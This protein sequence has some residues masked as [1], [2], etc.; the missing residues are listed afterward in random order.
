MSEHTASAWARCQCSTSYIKWG[1]IVGIAGLN[2]ILSW[3]AIRYDRY[4]WYIVF[5]SVGTL[6]KVLMIGLVCWSYVVWR[7]RSCFRPHVAITEPEGDTRDA[8]P[9]PAPIWTAFV[10]PCYTE[11]EE[12][13]RLTMNTLLAGLSHLRTHQPRVR[14]LVFVM[15]DGMAI[16][17]GNDRPT[18]EIVMDVLRPA[19][20]DLQ[21]KT[22]PP[23]PFAYP[24]WKQKAGEEPGG[25]ASVEM[26]LWEST[27]VCVVRKFRNQG[28][29]DSLIL[30]RDIAMSIGETDVSQTLSESNLYSVPLVRRMYEGHLACS[31]P[32]AGQRVRYMVGTDMGSFFAVNAF[33]DLVSA[34]EADP[35][36]L[37]ASG[38]IRVA[39]APCTRFWVE[40]QYF[41]YVMQ[42]GLTRYAQGLLGKVTC[43]PGCL[44]IIRCDDPA[45]LAEPMRRFR[46]CPAPLDP[47]AASAKA[48]VENI[49]AH[50]GEDRRFTGLLLYA[51]PKGRMILALG[52]TVYTDV[53]DTAVVFM[54]QRRRWFL[55]SQANNFRDLT[56]PSLPPLIRLVA[57]AQLWNFV[58]APLCV[59]CLGRLVYGV[60]V[61]GVRSWAVLATFSAVLFITL[62]KLGMAVVLADRPSSI[63]RMV[64]SMLLY[65]AICPFINTA[66]GM[67]ALATLDD[68]R[69][70]ATQRV[71]EQ[72]IQSVV[73]DPGD[74]NDD[75][76]V[77][78]YI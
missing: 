64:F 38:F 22:P 50:L 34:M 70:G 21:L 52:A 55:S 20:E 49:R 60:A 12:A 18:Y 44:Q 46:Q 54:S 4:P 37:G 48:V 40:Y 25:L 7:A 29:K 28:K 68:H 63:P 27:P 24:V 17:H 47:A 3:L 59:V 33:A 39:G 65:A 61:A 57:F 9:G 36:A 42:Q 13:V 41:E 67:Y 2:I 32:A 69:W 58:F 75:H 56:E 66:L 8:D 23:P 53:P 5:L 30:F 31:L 15:V 14:P 76:V 19:P 73:E 72:A 10:V 51:N 77:T 1:L 62:Y 45:K 6:Y 78:V 11:G 35:D 16:G 26:V 71:V 74:A 43:L